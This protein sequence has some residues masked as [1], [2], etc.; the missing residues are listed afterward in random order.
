MRGRDDVPEV[1]VSGVGATRFGNL[2]DRTM[3]ELVH[4]AVRAALDDA[5]MTIAEIDTVVD[6]GIDLLDGKGISNTDLMAP[7][8]V[9]LK[10]EVKVEEDG[11]VAA[12]YAL[13]RLRAGFC[14]TAL[15][16]GGSKAS[17]VNLD[18]YGTCLSDPVRERPLGLNRTTALALQ[19]AAYGDK[20]PKAREAAALLAARARRYASVRD[21]VEVREVDEEG[22][23][24]SP[25]LAG[26]L[27]RL[28]LVEPLDGVVAVVLAAGPGEGARIAGAG[29]AMD[30]HRLGHRRTGKLESCERASLQAY[31]EAG[32]DSA[33]TQLDLVET[34]PESAYHDLMIAEALG[35]CD[36]WEGANLTLDGETEIAGRL[37]INPSGGGLA[38]G[39]LVA[40]GLA[41]LAEVS[42]QVTGRAGM[43]QVP[44]ARRALAHGSSGLGMQSHCV[45]VVEAPR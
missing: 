17:T 37:P 42:R 25:L 36:R 40:S 44:R 34:S 8:G 10:E 4:E 2:S 39:P 16:F 6:A 24:A 14:R 28:D 33:R 31:R 11:L 5:R 19:A 7:A 26:P 45:V 23:L 18:E 21:D 35:L 43:R 22:I 32:I 12:H 15:V 13:L 30:A 3:P 29:L 27:R 9:Y 41:R 1:R 38:A 20:V